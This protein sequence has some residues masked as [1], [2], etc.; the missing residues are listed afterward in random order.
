MLQETQGEDGKGID[1]LEIRATCGECQK[2]GITT[3]LR[4]EEEASVHLWKE[5]WKSVTPAFT[6]NFMLRID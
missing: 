5:H 3:I 6:W 4:S 1:V 2:N